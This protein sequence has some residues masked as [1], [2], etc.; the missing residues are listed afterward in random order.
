MQVQ[1]PGLLAVPQQQQQAKEV[2]PAA[3][4]AAV[5][6]AE[7]TN[8]AQETLLAAFC[9]QASYPGMTADLVM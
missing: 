9:W 3:A 6:A 5:A 1:T 7:A 2:L 4:A 8:Q